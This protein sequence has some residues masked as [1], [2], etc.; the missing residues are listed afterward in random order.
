[1]AFDVQ[2][3]A[4][5]LE[6]YP[7]CT[8]K[9]LLRLLGRCSGNFLIEIRVFGKCNFQYFNDNDLVVSVEKCKFLQPQGKFLD[10]FIIPDGVQLDPHKI[11]DGERPQKVLGHGKLLPSFPAQSR[12]TPLPL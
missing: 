2:Y 7:L 6:M 8:I 11:Q 10:Q 5:L 3:D 12:S 9:L 4:Q 1:M